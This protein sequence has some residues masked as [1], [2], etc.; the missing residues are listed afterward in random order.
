MCGRYTLTTPPEAMR[1]I[2]NFENIPNLQPRFNIAPTQS[3]VTIRYLGNE[4]R[5]LLA[6]RWGLIPSWAKDSRAA[7]RMINARA[8]T[9]L[10]KPSFKEAFGKRRCLIPADGFYEWRRVIAQGWWI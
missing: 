4:K 7:S 9:L 2:F 5:V 8:E 10:D 1:A 3:I 6:A